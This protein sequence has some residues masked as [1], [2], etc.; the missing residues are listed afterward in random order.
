M[1]E[2]REI[3]ASQAEGGPPERASVLA[4][5]GCCLMDR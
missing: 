5:Q 3:L 2:K 4:R 1:A